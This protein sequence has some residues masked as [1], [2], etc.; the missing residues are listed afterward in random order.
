MS[1]VQ[2]KV[3]LFAGYDT[4]S[5]KSQPSDIRFC[6]DT[7][8]SQPDCTCTPGFLSLAFFEFRCF[9]LQWVLVELCKDQDVQNK[10]RE[11]LSQ[12]NGDPT[13]EQLTNE[14]PY[15]DAVVHETLRLHALL[16]ESSRVVCFSRFLP[17]TYPHLVPSSRPQKTT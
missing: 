17:S 4:T 12:I 10:L 11:E 16:G 15:L 13:W 14:L 2:M 1:T 5:S 8:F 6:F 7:V 9:C 3:L